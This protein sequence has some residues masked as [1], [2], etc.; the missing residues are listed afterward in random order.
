[1]VCSISVYDCCMTLILACLTGFF[2]SSALLS[3][4][5]TVHKVDFL[6]VSREELLSFEIPFSF[7]IDKTGIAIYVVISCGVSDTYSYV[8][9]A[10]CHGFGCWFDVNF[11]GSTVNVELS[12]GPDHPGT[13]W[14][15][16]TF[17]CN[18][19]YL[20]ATTD[21]LFVRY[22]QCRLLLREPIAVNRN[23]SISG[24]MLFE[25]NDKFSYC[26]TVRVQLDGTDV[27]TE[28]KINLH[29]QVRCRCI[30]G[31]RYSGLF[32]FLPSRC[33]TI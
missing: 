18:T 6:R 14:Y 22:P 9:S 3:S 29:D 5:R 28:N 17:S 27:Y 16:V 4:S 19:P 8:Y 30:N 20:A 26:V 15:Q 7:S 13:H 10:V 32:L 31:R 21:L 33:I 25:V 12:T 23:Q 2:P 24:S 1:M 11:I